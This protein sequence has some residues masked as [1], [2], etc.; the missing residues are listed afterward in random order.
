MKNAIVEKLKSKD[1]MNLKKTAWLLRDKNRTWGRTVDRRT[2]SRTL[3]IKGLEFDHAI[4][5]NAGDLGVKELYVALT[6]GAKSLTIMS[7]N[8]TFQKNPPLDLQPPQPV[9]T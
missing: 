5:L 9:V 3:L 7:A 1:S 4:I 6:R 2:V 8:P